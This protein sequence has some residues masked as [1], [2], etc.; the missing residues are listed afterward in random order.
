MSNEKVFQEALKK[1]LRDFY[2]KSFNEQIK[3]SKKVVKERKNHEPI[4]N[5]SSNN[6]N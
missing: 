3:R 1:L 5:G 2:I 6:S 4:N